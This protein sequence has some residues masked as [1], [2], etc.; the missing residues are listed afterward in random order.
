MNASCSSPAPR[1]L[2]PALRTSV[3]AAAVALMVL[4]TSPAPAQLVINEIL[5]N[6][7]AVDDADGEWFELYN[8]TASPVDVDGWT[9]RD[10]DI[11]SF[12]IAS[13][14][15]LLAP[16]GGYLVL[17]NNAEEAT[18]G[19]V[20]VDYE[21]SG[22]ALANT[23]DELVL[24]DAASSEID[25]VE[26]DDGATFPDPNGE[27]MELG[28]DPGL[29][30]NVGANWRDGFLLFGD[31]D[32]GTP[33]GPN[34]CCFS[35]SCMYL[36]V[37]VSTRA[38]LRATLHEAIDDHV[39]FP[40]ASVWDILELADED[41]GDSTRIL[42]VYKNASYPKVG[43]GTGDYDREHS[44][45]KSYG[46]PLEDGLGELPFSDCHHLFLAD[47]VYN[48]QGRSNNPYRDCTGPGCEEWPTLF[49]NGQG[50]PGQS[51]WKLG[52]GPEGTWETWPGRRG[53]VARAILYMDL[54]YEGGTHGA[55]AEEEP[56]LIA[57]DDPGQIAVTGGVAAVAY[58]GLLSD[59][60]A[61]HEED[62]PDELE[63]WRN[64]AVFS[65]QRNRNPFIDRP[66]WV[67]CVFLEDCG[68]FSDGFESGDVTGWS[69]AVP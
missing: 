9:V 53:D 49:N 38:A 44:W 40:Y 43:G 63:I 46:F 52:L 45:P 57:T 31:G 68:V 59:L 24:L 64:E 37:D 62:P 29:D 19:G 34:T 39:R 5:Q 55:T 41:P 32:R 7:S 35:E 65:Y 22:M 13:G 4:L 20:T 51:N 6:P 16:A 56:D 50:G 15:P 42:D 21:Y 14:G 36:E 48:E 1:V 8:P 28:K 67:R 17:G 54:R 61:W 33:G 60:L 69:S 10:N 66:D 2:R 11:D 58:M 25:R 47:K 12:V 18:N 30:N 3:L 27:S 26:W 23:S